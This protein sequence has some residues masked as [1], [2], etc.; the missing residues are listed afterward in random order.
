MPWLMPWSVFFRFIASAFSNRVNFQTISR[1]QPVRGPVMLERDVCTGLA[2]GMRPRKISTAA[3]LA[4]V[5]CAAAVAAH[6]ST[7]T[8]TLSTDNAATTNYPGDG[9]GQTG[10]LRSAILNSNSGDTIQFNCG[11]PCVITLNGPLPPIVHDLTIDGGSLGNVIVNGNNAYRVF[12]VDTGNVQL[13]NLQIQNARAKGGDGGSGDWGCG[14]AGLGAGLFVNGV[15]AAATVTLTDVFFLGDSANGGNGCT[16]NGSTTGAG[17]GGGWGRNGGN[18]EFSTAPTSGGGGGVLGPGANGDT[19]DLNGSAGGE[20]GGGGSSMNIGSGI[21]GLGG[22]GYSTN[23]AVSP[24]EPEALVVVAV[25][26]VHL[27]VSPA[28]EVLLGR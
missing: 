28:R 8:V 23:S 14:G 7:L 19:S 1:R 16:A 27:A 26:A 18:G 2:G 10:D 9:P 13:E 6:A 22:S 4:A 12:F 24:E 5:L 11:S 21:P 15:S 25:A 3:A 20:G 17:G